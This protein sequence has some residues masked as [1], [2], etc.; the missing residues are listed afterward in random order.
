MP[1]SAP[2]VIELNGVS[3][4]CA[5]GTTLAAVVLEQAH[6]P[7]AIATAVNGAFVARHLRHRHRLNNGDVVL[8]F[9]PMVG[10]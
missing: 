8:F 9:A 2:L 5:S 4:V 6:D 7:L 3:R 10:G 1:E